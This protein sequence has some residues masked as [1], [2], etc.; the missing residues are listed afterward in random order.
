[1][2]RMVLSQLS[3]YTVQIKWSYIYC[4]LHIGFFYT[5]HLII[6]QV[7]LIVTV[8]IVFYGLITIVHIVLFPS[9]AEVLKA[10]LTCVQFWNS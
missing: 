4:T 5:P 2:K 6:T 3:S 1:M 10:Y 9:L 7:A 8:S